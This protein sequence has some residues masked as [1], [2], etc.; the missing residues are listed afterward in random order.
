MKELILICIYLAIDLTFQLKNIKDFR[1]NPLGIALN[2]G[3][4][5]VNTGLPDNSRV[6]AYIDLDSDK[7]VD[8]II[9]EKSEKSKDELISFYNYNYESGLFIKSGIES[10]KIDNIKASDKIY[11]IIPTS[12]NNDDHVDLIISTIDISNPNLLNVYVYLG[13]SSTKFIFRSSFATNSGIMVLNIDGS[14]YSSLLYFDID[15]NRRVVSKYD[16]NIE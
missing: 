5:Q 11:E 4:F 15:K 16:E 14:N 12:L 3:V 1:T 8:A 7:K 13:S 2:E 6:M 9:V 10:L